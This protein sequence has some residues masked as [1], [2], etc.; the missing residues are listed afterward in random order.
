MEIGGMHGIDQSL[1]YTINLKMPR[2]LIG[3]KG[4]QVVNDLISKANAKGVP[5]KV[6]ETVN[7]NVKMLGTITAPDIRFDLKET[8]G[9]VTDQT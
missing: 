6:G 7:L 2:A 4:N 3:T 1:D 8:A 9:S 5:V